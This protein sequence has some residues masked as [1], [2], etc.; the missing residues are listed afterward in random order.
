MS[1]KIL[2]LKSSPRLKGNSSTLAERAAVGAR[3]AGADVEIIDLHGM[4][5]RPC[6]ACEECK[7]TGGVC[8]I[9]DEMQSLY[10]RLRRADAILLASPIYWFT[11]SAQL[12]LCID[13]WYALQTPDGNELGGKRFGI[14]LTYGDSDLHNSGGINAIHTFESMFRYLKSEITG[15]VHGSADA[16]GDVEKQ[17]ALMEQAFRLGQKLV[18]EP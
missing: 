15:I 1:K 4:N 8:V 10:P 6:D 16:P 18:R 3:E 9:G 13:R 14:I 17:P 12:K 2:I 11:M 5:I 7:E